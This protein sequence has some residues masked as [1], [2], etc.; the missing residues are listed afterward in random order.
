MPEEVHQGARKQQQVRENADNVLKVLA[1]QQR[2]AK[3]KDAY[4]RVTDE[5]TPNLAKIEHRATHWMHVTRTWL[6]HP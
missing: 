1:R 6:H 5:A 3:G 2:H 4:H